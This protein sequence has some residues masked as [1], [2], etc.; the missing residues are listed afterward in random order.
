[1]VA[2]L[3]LGFAFSVYTVGARSIYNMMSSY[4]AFTR[5]PGVRP[6]GLGVRASDGALAYAIPRSAQTAA[7]AAAAAYNTDC[8][9]LSCGTVLL[10]NNSLA[11]AWLLC[12]CRPYLTQGA[13]DGL[14]VLKSDEFD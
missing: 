6:K 4:I 13:A 2:A 10:V 7:A 14:L 8:H 11:A 3:L 1:M 5:L 9:P 12:C